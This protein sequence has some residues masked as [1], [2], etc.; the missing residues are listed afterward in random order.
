[1][2]TADQV[3]SR[4]CDFRHLT[5]TE[6]C[7]YTEEDANKNPGLREAYDQMFEAIVDKLKLLYWK[8]VIEAQ[9]EVEG[10]L[11]YGSEPEPDFESEFQKAIR[12]SLNDVPVASTSASDTSQR[13]ASP[14]DQAHGKRTMPFLD[15]S[16]S[17]D[18]LSERAPKRK[19]PSPG[20]PGLPTTSLPIRSRY[21]RTHS[22]G[23]FDA[24]PGGARLPSGP[25][26]TST[27]DSA[28][29]TLPGRW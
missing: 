20:G 29:T 27:S 15:E 9:Y 19:R 17:D 1:M 5:N 12:A 6:N 8:I 14:T 2:I 26:P 16:D 11:P 13:N 21:P 28:T 10:E 18:S 3:L 25:L 24:P 22:L 4:Y 7:G 23:P